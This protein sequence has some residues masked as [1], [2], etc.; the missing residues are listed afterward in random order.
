MLQRDAFVPHWVSTKSRDFNSSKTS[1]RVTLS[2]AIHDLCISKCIYRGLSASVLC[3]IASGGSICCETEPYNPA[4]MVDAL[5]TSNPRPTWYSSVPTIH[6]STVNFIRTI[7]SDGDEKYVS[8][9]IGQNMIWKRATHAGGPGHSLRMIRS[10]AA[11]LLESDAGLLS[12]TYDG[13]PIVPTY[14]MSE[15]MPIS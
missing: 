3:T 4:N 6:N 8:Y 7:A 14:S 2:C 5:A 15:Q 1:D 11:A 12:S 13:V 9:G 10:G